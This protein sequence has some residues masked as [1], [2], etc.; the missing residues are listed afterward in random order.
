M[1]PAPR[2]APPSPAWGNN[3]V[4]M[5]MSFRNSLLPAVLALLATGCATGL[6][7]RAVRSERPDYNQQIVRSADAEILLNLVRLRYNDSPL[8]LELGGIVAQYNYDA[9]LS[10]AGTVGSGAG[11]A[12][13]GSGLEY[14]EKPTITYT[15]LGGE[16]FASRMLAP[17][18]LDAAMLFA[19]SGWSVERL[20]LVIVQRVNDLFNAPTASGPTPERRPDYEAFADFAER[21]HRLQT[22]GLIGVNW[23]MTKQDTNAPGED[24]RFWLRSPADPRSP[25]AADVAA[26]RRYLALA[27]GREEFELTAFPFMRRSSEVGMRCR[28]LLGVLYFLS[29]A[30]EPPAADVQAGLVTVTRDDDGRPF[31]WSKVTGKLMRIRSQK[32]RP[33]NASVAVPYRDWWFYIADDDQSSKITFS[34][35]NILFS[36]QAASGKGKSPLLTL[37]VGR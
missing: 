7:A 3:S 12:T 28:S 21:F 19:Q 14:S 29:A 26:V 25:L 34:L 22:A 33:S 13:I 8:F 4:P 16:E 5:V 2:R 24:A 17:I 15:P 10:A 27:P 32:A 36:L 18:P 31:D 37:P 23:E 20:L 9:T 1:S 30:V 11:S 35:V 6:G